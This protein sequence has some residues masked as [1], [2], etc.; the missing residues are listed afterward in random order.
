[1]NY[2]NNRY[3]S[4]DILKGFGILYLI[5]LHQLVWALTQGDGFGVLFKES[6]HF[7]YFFAYKSGFHVLGFQVP[8]LAGVSYYM[9]IS[10]KNLSF[11][12]ILK[13][14]LYLVGLG[15]LMNFLT[16]GATWTF[17]WD[18][19]QYIA[20][21]MVISYPLLKLKKGMLLIGILGLVT[22]FLSNKFPLDSFG[23][24]YLYKIII[25][26]SQGLSYWAMCPWYALFASGIIMGR[27]FLQNQEKAL[28][29]LCGFGLVLLWMS[30]FSGKHFPEISFGTMWGVTLFK[31]S[32]FFILG[33]IG[34]CAFM[35]ALL[36]ILFLRYKKIKELF[37]ESVFEYWGKGILWIYLMH[38]V[39]G[40]HI[41]VNMLVNYFSISYHQTLASSLILIIVYLTL[42]YYISR[43]I[44]KWKKKIKISK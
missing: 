15:F 23:Q 37:T 41:T 34:A 17:D 13:R 42:G 43:W 1:M 27:I 11:L 22:L 26:D 30:L 5:V 4:L 8:M 35:S 29:T 31:P 7:L 20:L 44:V 39:L 9:A 6:Y 3:L 40:Y 38:I 21:S 18:V 10:T 2:R 14:A 24:Y 12:Y 28:K 19:L 16:W 32:S 25:G 33:I 36:E